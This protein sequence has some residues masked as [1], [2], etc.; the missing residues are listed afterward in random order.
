[1]TEKRNGIYMTTFLLFWRLPRCILWYALL[2]G[3]ML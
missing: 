2:H 3:I 1:M